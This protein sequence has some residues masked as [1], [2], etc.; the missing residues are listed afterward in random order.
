[1]WKCPICGR[2]FST[3]YGLKAHF[4]NKHRYLK[5]CRK[6]RLAYAKYRGKIT[7]VGIGCKLAIFTIWPPELR[8]F[9]TFCSE[10]E[11]DP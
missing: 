3:L 7:W 4:A 6:A 5:T 1:M 2:E 9:C 8:R 11:P 10:Y